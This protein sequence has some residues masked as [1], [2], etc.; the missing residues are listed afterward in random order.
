MPVDLSTADLAFDSGL[1]LFAHCPACRE[2]VPANYNHVHD[3]TVIWC[4][5]CQYRFVSA[6]LFWLDQAGWEEVGWKLD[7]CHSRVTPACA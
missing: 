4:P 2:C 6:D 3:G 7:P 1:I 5:Q